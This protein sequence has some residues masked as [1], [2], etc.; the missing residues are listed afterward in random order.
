MRAGRRHCMALRLLCGLVL[1]VV[2]APAVAIAQ[3][4]DFGVGGI[5]D[6]PSARMNPEDELTVTYSRKDVA[7]IYAIGY[8]VLPRVEASFRYTI[9]NARKSSTVPGV[10]CVAN[11]FTICDGLRDRSFE[12]K[13]KLL[14]ESEYLPD[15]SV[16]IRDL[17]GT[18]AWGSEYLSPRSG[19]ART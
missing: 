12:V 8:Q 4:N 2:M 17:L 6:I 19:S 10:S 7:D 5:L 16:G 13:V 14:E 18:G 11:E 3:A 1:A 15:V 9:F